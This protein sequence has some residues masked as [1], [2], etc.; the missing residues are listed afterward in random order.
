MTVKI[1]PGN[2]LTPA[3]IKSFGRTL[4]DTH[5]LR[6]AGLSDLIDRFIDIKL[7]KRVNWL[8]TYA[9]IILIIEGGKLTPSELGR[10]LC[11]SKEN[12]TN[13]IDALVKDGLVKRYRS[14]RDRRNVQI[15]LTPDGVR[16]MKE[17][18]IEIQEEEE[19]VKSWLTPAELDA[20]DKLIETFSFFLSGRARN[21]I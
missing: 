4:A 11:R 14:G 6:L 16:Y 17:V 9:M 3:E 12:M 8:K 20:V 1:S 15:A 21:S 2:D 18:L 19:L 13:L 7:K 10:S 5:L